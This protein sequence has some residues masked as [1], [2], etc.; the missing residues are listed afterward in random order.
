MKEEHP[1]R[2]WMVASIKAVC[3]WKLPCKTTSYQRTFMQL[4]RNGGKTPKWK[5]KRCKNPTVPALVSVCFFTF[6][7]CFPIF[8]SFHLISFHFSSF[9]IF[10]SFFLVKFLNNIFI[11]FFGF[12]SF[13]SFSL[14][15]FP[16]ALLFHVLI[17]ELHLQAVELAK[18]SA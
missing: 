12:I 8:V 3:A 5:N 16:L 13:L 7:I 17:T 15:S 10:M 11:H 1:K 4:K 9:L 6:L 18:E 2:T 14:L